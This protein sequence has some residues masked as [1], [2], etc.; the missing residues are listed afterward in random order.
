MAFSPVVAAIR[1]GEGLSPDLAPPI[2][3]EA[4]LAQLDASGPEPFAIPTFSQILPRLGEVSDM[5]RAFRRERDEAKREVLRKAFRAEQRVLVRAQAGHAKQLFA[6]AVAGDAPFRDRLTRFW[7]DHFTVVGKNNL[8]RYAIPHYHEEAIRPHVAGRFADML[9]A[10]VT[11]PMMLFYLD[12]TAS[13]GPG[14][15][16]AKGRRGLNENLARELLELHIL[17]VGGGY[18]QADV[19]ELAELLTGLTAQLQ[20]GFSFDPKRAEPG[21]ET[22]LGVSY[23]GADPALADVFAALEDLA[24]HPETAAHLARKLAVHFCADAPDP[25]MV[26]AMTRAYLTH[27]GA[28]LPVYR[29]MLEHPFAWASF[30]A[31]VKQPIDFVTS[32][33]RALAL[34]AAS[35]ERLSL[36]KLTS[37]VTA[38]LA[39]MGQPP[40]AP[41]G[42]DGWPEEAENWVTPQGLAARLQWAM[43]GPSAFFR[44]LP[45]PRAFVDTA[46]GD[47]ADERVRFAAASAENR[48]EGVGLILASPVFQRR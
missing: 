21:A 26:D 8:T 3:V 33:L 1:F 45:D 37:F 38:P 43:A 11:H 44:G 18:G 10:V 34:P 22:V 7:G 19:R 15:V 9:K 20:G 46:L 31:K 40:Y 29:A 32:S 47:V 27:D 36:S 12:Q 4:V 14:S 6:R 30:G 5:R 24:M 23:G 2:S 25:G 39:A 28:L 16:A 35:L 13:F 17:G 42:P 48:R 41:L